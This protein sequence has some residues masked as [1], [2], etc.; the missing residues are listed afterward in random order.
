MTVKVRPQRNAAVAVSEENKRE[1]VQA[2]RLITA[3]R[4]NDDTQNEYYKCSK[5]TLGKY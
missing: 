4:K 3:A 5:K 1:K 2:Y